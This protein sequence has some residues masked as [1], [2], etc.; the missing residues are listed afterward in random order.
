MPSAYRHILRS[1]GLLGA[2]QVLQAGLAVVR[3]K[4]AA[5]L[6]GAAG[7]GLADLAGRTADTLS[8]ATNLGLGTSGVQ[9]LALLRAAGRQRGAE[10]FVCLLR[11][12]SLLTAVAGTAL[13]LALSPLLARWVTGD[14][15]RTADF[16]AAA[17]AVGFM[18]LLGAETAI[19]KACKRLRALALCSLGAAAATLVVCTAL[20]AL[21]GLRG[22]GPALSLSSLA[23]C[24][25]HLHASRK[26]YAWRVRFAC[27]LPRAARRLVA[28]G[29]AY[30]GAGL[31]GSLAE[32]AVRALVARRGGAAEAGHFA[33]G[34]ALAVAYAR[35]V[36]VAMD[37]D[38]YPRLS[39]AVKTK[40]FSGEIDRQTDVLVLLTAPM[41][42]VFAALV[43]VL[44]PLLYSRDFAPAV[45]MALCAAGYM[46]CKAGYTPLSY[47]ALARADGRTF[48]VMELIYDAIFVVLT[49]GLYLRFGLWGAGLGLT[50]ANAAD[51]LLVRAVY[52][53]RYAYRPSRA[54][55]ARFCGGG[56]LL[57]AGIAL[58]AA[59]R[60]PWLYA[61]TAAAVVRSLWWL[62]R[63][64][65]S[66]SVGPQKA[67][68]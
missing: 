37:A 65:R 29:T 60:G 48:L 25:I 58:A 66:A 26:A 51:W 32:L 19:L 44:V 16:A 49:C 46:Y 3:S 15:A 23:A 63:L 1:T 10:A 40:S 64:G 21:W 18:A 20:Y 22:I 24:A 53:R 30:V 34:F 28:L 67:S 14:A 54:T 68:S 61:L 5:L 8:G 17:P 62:R 38:Y 47:L 27:R 39:A 55:T 42:L 33:A 9:R 12:L 43:P 31:A 59:G 4:A 36:F 50:L 57:M 41:M 56:A 52:T 7:V 2:V 6:I 13:G 11:S 35:L 45:A